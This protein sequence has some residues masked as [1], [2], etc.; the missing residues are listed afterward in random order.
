[1]SSRRLEMLRLAVSFLFWFD[2]TPAPDCNPTFLAT[3]TYKE[4]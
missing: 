4:L 2:Q 3:L 1:M